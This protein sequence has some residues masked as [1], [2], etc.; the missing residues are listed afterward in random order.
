MLDQDRPLRRARRRVGC[1]ARGRLRASR[2][3]GGCDRGDADRGGDARRAQNGG[4]ADPD[5]AR[6][7]RAE[8]AGHAIAAG[9]H[10]AITLR[11]IRSSTPTATSTRFRISPPTASAPTASA[12]RRST[13]SARN[14]SSNQA[15]DDHRRA[16]RL[17]HVVCRSPG[18]DHELGDDLAEPR[19]Q[20]DLRDP[21]RVAGPVLADRERDQRQPAQRDER[22]R[23]IR[24][25]RLSPVRRRAARSPAGRSPAARSSGSPARDRRPPP[26]RPAFAPSGSRARRRT[27]AARR[28]SAAPASSRSAPPASTRSGTG[29]RP[30]ARR[31]SRRRAR[32]PACARPRRRPARWRRRRPPTATAGPPRRSR[33]PRPYPGHAVV[34]R[35]RG[36]GLR[37]QPEHLPGRVVDEQGG[38]ALVEP[39][40]LM[41]DPD[42][43][44]RGREDR[45]RRDRERRRRAQS[46]AQTAL[47][48]TQRGSSLMG[49]S[50]NAHGRGC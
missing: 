47:T 27:R 50:A 36:L 7:P 4:G 2:G 14:A 12:E 11:V 39:E 35:W 32:R 31:R 30:S 45:Q 6:A 15:D 29:C 3:A 44:Q 26:T 17:E 21:A 22:R 19:A 38:V 41:A 20:R 49:K 37:D 10:S 24:T 46:A 16:E 5:Q 28:R 42:E 1:R 18:A 43:A 34:Q 25:E 8:P 13:R 23:A 33:T 48:G 9:S 40:A